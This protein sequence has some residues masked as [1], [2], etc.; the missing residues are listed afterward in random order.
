MSQVPQVPQGGP[1]RPQQSSDETQPKGRTSEKFT[2]L[3]K[4]VEST[5]AEKQGKRRERPKLEEEPE[6]SEVEVTFAEEA[7]PPAAPLTSFYI[8]DSASSSF[9]DEG[10]FTGLGAPSV[11][12]YGSE[13]AL[14]TD[15]SWPSVP[16]GAAKPTFSRPSAE[17]PEST[18]S[19]SAVQSS[20]RKRAAEGA[21]PA[22]ASTRAAAATKPKKQAAAEGVQE[23]LIAKHPQAKKRVAAKRSPSTQVLTEGAQAAPKKEKARAKPKAKVA[24]QK[25]EKAEAEIASPEGTKKRGAKMKATAAPPEEAAAVKRATAE[26]ARVRKQKEAETETTEAM[27]PGLPY[28]AQAALHHVSTVPAAQGSKIEALSG[29]PLPVVATRGVAGVSAAGGP[30]GTTLTRSAGVERVL[31]ALKAAVLTLEQQTDKRTLTITLKGD[32]RLAGTA[33]DGL[34]ISV[35]EFAAAPKQYNIT[36]ESSPEAQALLSGAAADMADQLNRL[37]RERGWSVQRLDVQVGRPLFHRKE[38]GDMGRGAGGGRGGKT[39]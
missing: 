17:A 9:S 33:L 10:F 22:A 29:R 5:D 18:A 13:P 14:S 24:V 19:D 6:V 34:K 38:A 26:K 39:S 30:T 1:G 16:A 11:A 25:A 15:E 2:R 31:A 27:A 23:G 37:G 20:R 35:E 12:G 4:E 28:L 7:L 8:P 21:E 3:I 36:M 32:P